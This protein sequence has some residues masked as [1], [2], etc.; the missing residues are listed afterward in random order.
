[1]NFIRGEMHALLSWEPWQWNGAVDV[2]K[3][4]TAVLH[5]GKLGGQWPL[6]T[7]LRT[8]GHAIE[9]HAYGVADAPSN[10]GVRWYPEA[11]VKAKNVAVSL[12]NV[13]ADPDWER[14]IVELP[15]E[16]ALVR[17]G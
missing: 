17:D 8:H 13:Y 12:A 1:M 6:S 9:R 15:V 5:K 3:P 2:S 11:I 14:S 4:R 16:A 10:V 7:E